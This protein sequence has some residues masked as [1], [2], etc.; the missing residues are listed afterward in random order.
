MIS[1]FMTKRITIAEGGN[2]DGLP[3]CQIRG[4]G[5]HGRYQKR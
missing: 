4:V 3:T 2:G 1:S 5:K